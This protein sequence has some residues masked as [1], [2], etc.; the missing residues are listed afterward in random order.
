MPEDILTNGSSEPVSEVVATE[1]RKHVPHMIP[2]DRVKK[3]IEKARL[4]ALEE[5]KRQMQEQLQSHM[6][7]QVAQ[8]NMPTA[9]A[10]Q[11]QVGQLPLEQLV[12]QQIQQ[13]LQTQSNVYAE[14]QK[15]LQEQKEAQERMA[16]D[17]EFKRKMDEE[18]ARDPE[19]SKDFANFNLAPYEHVKYLAT[20][21]TDNTGAVMRDLAKRKPYLASLQVLAERDPQAAAQE[22]QLLSQSLKD[23]DSA[24]AQAAKTTSEDPIGR[25]T[26]SATAGVDNGKRSIRDWKRD[27]R[28][29]F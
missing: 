21:S 5:G 6:Q 1:E 17:N 3:M 29:R 24:V 14:Q 10:M 23:R 13:A 20:L 26:P 2:D 15:K 18:I 22:L 27:P 4:E 11:Q 8:P 28:F 19:A 9:P 7:P 25:M 12:Q 16:L